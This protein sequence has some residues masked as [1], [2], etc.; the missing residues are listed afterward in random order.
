MT[1]I[2]FY[3]L[4][5]KKGGVI[6]DSSDDEGSDDGIDGVTIRFLRSFENSDMY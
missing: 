4:C 2:S 1:F 6:I 5:S 3:E